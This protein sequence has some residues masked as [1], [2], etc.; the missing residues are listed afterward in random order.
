MISSY[1]ENQIE[2]EE[3]QFFVPVLQKRKEEKESLEM[4]I[5]SDLKRLYQLYINLNF[6][7]QLSPRKNIPIKLAEKPYKT[8]LKKMMSNLG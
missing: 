3:D 2:N 6:K 5:Q 1:V 7:F 4:D 8:K